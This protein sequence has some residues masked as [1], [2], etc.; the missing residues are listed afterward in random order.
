MKGRLFYWV[1]GKNTMRLTPL[2]RRIYDTVEP[3]ATE[4]NLLIVNVSLIG[5]DGMPTVQIM[6]E[7]LDTA[8]LTVEQCAA[9]SRAASVELDVEDPVSGKYR[10]EVS[11]PGIDRVLTREADFETYK[12]LEAKLETDVPLENGQKKF[13]GV[14]QGIENGDIT[15][16]TDQGD[17]VVISF[18]MI[19]KAKLVLTDELIKATANSEEKEM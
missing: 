17:V 18:E 8:K 13:R 11:S 2:E 5:H 16:K 12:G 6:A 19:R 14:L 3:V 9:L 15:M 4:L 7:D 10:L 1:N